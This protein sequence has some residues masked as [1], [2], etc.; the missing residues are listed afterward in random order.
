MSNE[1]E[2]SDC[3]TVMS[4][5]TWSSDQHTVEMC[6]HDLPSVRK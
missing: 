4:D 3:R 2:L 6:V 1:V 5:S